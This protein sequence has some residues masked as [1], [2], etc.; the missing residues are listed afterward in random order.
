MR[1]W[2]F[3]AV[4][5]QGELED[6]EVVYCHPP[7]GYETTGSDGRTRMC[8]ILKPVYGM[9]QAGRRWQCSLFPRLQFWGFKQ[10]SSDPCVFTCTK[11]INGVSQSIIIG[12]YVDDLFVLYSDDS[13]NSLYSS[14]KTDLSSRRNV[15]DE[16]PVS[17]LLNVDVT[18]DANC[19][20]LEQER[21]IAQLVDTYLPEG[22]PT[23]FQR[24][25]APA[26]ADLPLVI[27]AALDAKARGLTP[28]PTLRT[29]YQSLEVGV[30][31]YCATQTRPNIA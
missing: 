9:A 24:N 18:T 2:D 27:A 12:C 6:G 14:F 21:Y 30:L 4:Y 22:V 31:L 1:R 26:G 10:C 16:G 11:D 20:L 13:T 8:R 28:D 23:A 3:V 7:P 29:T 15:E 19:V 25:H 17:D 5:L